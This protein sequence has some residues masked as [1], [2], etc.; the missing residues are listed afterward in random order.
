MQLLPFSE[1]SIESHRDISSLTKLLRDQ[2]AKPGLITTLGKTGFVGRVGSNG[3][4]IT[5]RA[6]L[7]FTPMP[8]VHG[9]FEIKDGTVTLRVQMIPSTLLLIFFATVF[10][11]LSVIIF[12]VG[13]HV[14]GATLSV[15]AVVWFLSMSSFWLDG[16]DSR[17]ALEK[18]CAT[19]K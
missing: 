12:D 2:T 17:R 7:P 10:N 15:A 16:G 6:L 19:Q 9:S 3:F 11:L 8:E 5:R 18:L 4:C 13:G 1:F 14:F